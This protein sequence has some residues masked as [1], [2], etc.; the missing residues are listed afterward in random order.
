MSAPSP[1]RRSD[2]LVAIWTATRNR[3]KAAGVASPVLDAR[4]LVE[5]AA[6]V[7]RLDIVTDPYRI[8]PPEALR[9]LNAL[10][11]R[12]EAREPLAYILGAREFWSLKLAVSP[13]VL[14]PRPET[15]TLVDAAL[16]A[17]AP[18]APAAVLD[19][20]TGSG[21]ILLSVLH[22]RPAASGVGVDISEAALAIARANA[23][24]LGLDARARFRAGDWGAGLDGPFDLV[25]SNPPYIPTADI[26]GLEP[27][28]ARHEPRL[29]LD[30]GPNG[31][32]AYRRLAPDLVR[33]LKPGGRFALE[34][35]RGQAGPV[36]AILR[37]AGLE[38]E[39]VRADLAGVGRV[40]AGRRPG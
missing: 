26:D 29:A 3:L 19:L 20:G 22:E 5:A 16:A 11:E 6:G 13:A 33:L 25:L 14:T 21:A 32:D 23:A 2:T 17:L 36:L 37:A 35:G 9:R 12:R 39:V 38:P 8:V 10:T 28:V 31:L 40:V 7:A 30:G 24:A 15:E 1:D 4:L 34:V 18:D 27:E